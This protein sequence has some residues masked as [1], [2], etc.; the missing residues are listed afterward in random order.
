[1]SPH[2]LAASAIDIAPFFI[3]LGIIFVA[4]ALAGRLADIIGLSPIPFYLLV[5][6]FLGNQTLVPLVASEEFIQL[7][8]EIGVILLLFMLGLEY[9]GVELK[10]GLRRGYIAGLAD[11][12]LN[13]APGVAFGLLIGME[14]VVALLLG[15]VTYISSSGIISKLFGDLGWLGNRETP[16]ILSILVFEDLVMAVYLPLMSVLLVGAALIDGLTSLAIAALTVV[17]VMFVAL[18]FGDRLSHWISHRSD[19]IVLLTAFAI[20]LLVAGVTQQLEVSAAVGAFLVGIAISEPVVERVHH[21]TVPLRDIFAA[22]F[23]VFFGLQIDFAALVPLLPFAIILAIITFISKMAT[24]V[25]AARRDGVSLFGQM[26]TGSILTIR[27]EF[28]VVIAG[29]AA[30]AGLEAPQL[31]PLTAGYVLIM[32]I[33]GSILV[34]VVNPAMRSFMAFRQ[35]R[36]TAR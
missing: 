34:R 23:F 27:G 21:L 8:A 11:L 28:S 3:E 1:M 35:K 17:V 20:V 6:L 18:R 31:V 33:V 9:T 7:G 5:G 29:L 19:E 25:F 32:A 22:V 36:Q 2:I 30:T 10:D 16:V 24:G 15:G 14:P 12:A 4:L 26:R 13:F